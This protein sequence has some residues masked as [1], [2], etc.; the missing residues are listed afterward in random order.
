[1]TQVVDTNH[2]EYGLGL[3]WKNLSETMVNA[4]CRISGNTAIHDM[5]NT[6]QL[7]PVTTELSETVTKHHDIILSNPGT[8]AEGSYPLIIMLEWMVVN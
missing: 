7:R 8:L 4:G 1:M 5:L 2:Q 3:A 6:Q